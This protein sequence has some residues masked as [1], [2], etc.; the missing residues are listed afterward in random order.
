MCRDVEE[1]SIC[2]VAICMN[3][4]QLTLALK[5]IFGVQ[6]RLVFVEMWSILLCSYYFCMNGLQFT[7]VL[8]SKFGVQVRLVCV[9]MW[10]KFLYFAICNDGYTAHILF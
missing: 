4:L 7:L 9:G 3:G 5:S 8:K 6:V 10:R 2:Y 1:I